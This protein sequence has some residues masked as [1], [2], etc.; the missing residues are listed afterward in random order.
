MGNTVLIAV[1]VSAQLYEKMAKQAA[2]MGF[3]K[4]DGTANMSEYIRHVIVITQQKDGR[5]Q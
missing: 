2:E 4:N 1:R 5:M 3:V